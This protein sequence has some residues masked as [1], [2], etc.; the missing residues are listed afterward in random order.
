MEDGEIRAKM[1]RNGKRRPLDFPDALSGVVLGAAPS[2]VCMSFATHV[3]LVSVVVELGKMG[4]W[5]CLALHC[6]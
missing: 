6:L 3:N 2:F 4:T 5:I 1:W